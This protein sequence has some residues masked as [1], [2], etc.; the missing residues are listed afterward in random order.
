M[1]LRALAA[2]QDRIQK[3]GARIVSIMPDTAQYTSG[4]AV[5]T[6]ASA[7]EAVNKL[8]EGEYSLVLSELQMESPEAGLQVLAHARMMDY[9]PA[10]AIVT[11]YQTAKPEMKSRMLIKPEDLEAFLLQHA[12]DR[13]QP[14]GPLRVAGRG[15]MLEAGRMGDEERGHRRYLILRPGERKRDISSRRA[16]RR[17]C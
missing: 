8:E 16:P 11:T 10:T 15:E 5:Q 4:Y 1:E 17:R 12:L 6:A 13:A 9:K 3:F 14:V 7:A 2:A